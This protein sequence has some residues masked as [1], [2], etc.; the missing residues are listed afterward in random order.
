MEECLRVVLP[1][2]KLETNKYLVGTKVHQIT[3][4]DLDYAN[5]VGVGFLQLQATIVTEAKS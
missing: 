3:M 5:Q 4:K 2:I 1:V